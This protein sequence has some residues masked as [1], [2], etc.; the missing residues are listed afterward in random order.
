MRC[1]IIAGSPDVNIDFI[2]NFVKSDDFVICADRGYDYA[3]KAGIAPDIVAGDFDS[4]SVG[5]F[6]KCRV[7]KLN[8]HKD[9]TD[10]MHCID[11]ALENHCTQIAL[12]A[13]TGGRFDHSFANV[14][15]L[16]YIAQ[17]GAR[18]MLIS[19]DEHIEFLSKGTYNF[20]GCDG[21]T[22]SVFPFGCSSVNVTYENVEYPL[23]GYSLQSSV[24][25]GISNVFISDKCKI[26]INDGNAIIIINC[27]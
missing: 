1:V 26:K 19:P 3:V 16:Q 27:F 7:V 18:G 21:K 12:L 11:M 6:D 25:L 22:F 9:D 15:A 2:R 17:K 24:P 14:S 10:T 13:A 20:D 4:S 23:D 8:V 5:V